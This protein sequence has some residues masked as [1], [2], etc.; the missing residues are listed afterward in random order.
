MSSNIA[1]MIKAGHP[2]EQAIAAAYRKAG[3]DRGADKAFDA[4]VDAALR[5]AAHDA[6]AFDRSSVRTYDVDGHLRVASSVVSAAQINPYWGKEI[7]DAA[8]LGLDPNRKYML[9]RDPVALE[10]ATP[11][12]Q[13]KPLLIRH[14]AITADDH[15]REVVIGSVI[16]PVWEP[17][18]ILAELIVWDA[19]A[20]KLIE[21]GERSDLS[22]G[23]RYKA[24]MEPGI[25]NGLPFDGKMEGILFNHCAIVSDGRVSGAMV[26]DNALI[27]FE[28]EWSLIEE[29]IR[30]CGH[31]AILQ[32]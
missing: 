22:C 2:R 10:A 15:D 16:N 9:L 24:R 19:D 6:V 23:Y 1:E 29:A 18:N 28:A 3:K 27:D 25:H 32:V 26:A 11:S 5:P 30:A 12:L 20:I 21:S 13:G 8:A 14:K 17:P 7:P 4:E 31:S